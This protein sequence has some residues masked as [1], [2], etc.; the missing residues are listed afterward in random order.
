MHHMYTVGLDVDTLVSIVM[1]TLLLITGL[2]AG[3]LEYF[4]GPLN[5]VYSVSSF[6]R[7]RRLR[8][9]DPLRWSGNK[10]REQ[11]LFGKIQSLI[12]EHIESLSDLLSGPPPLWGGCGQEVVPY[13]AHV[14]PLLSCKGI[15]PI[16][17]TVDEGYTSLRSAP[18]PS[19]VPEVGGLNMENEQSAG[20]LDHSDSLA[21]PTQ[22][23]LY[24]KGGMGQVEPQ[25]LS[26]L[27]ATLAPSFLFFQKQGGT[28]SPHNSPKA[29]PLWGKKHSPGPGFLSSVL[30]LGAG[31]YTS[32]CPVPPSEALPDIR[33]AGVDSYI[34]DHMCKH[35]RPE[36]D[37]EFGYYLAGLIE[38]DG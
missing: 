24:T 33:R 16:Y 5:L 18:G 21:F 12:K 32:F 15:H 28:A 17:R 11:T 4:I 29:F 1:A 36:T 14:C 13:G 22:N 37:E 31:G 27:I 20:N 34:S 8:S 19:G 30:R 6:G 23:P 38:G 35:V 7:A 10:N 2:Y 3:K 26:K 25:E 9:G